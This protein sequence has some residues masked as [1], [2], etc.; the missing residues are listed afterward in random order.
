MKQLRPFIVVEKSVRLVTR[1]VTVHA[2]TAEAAI[3]LASRPRVTWDTV[4]EDT[5]EETFMAYDKQND[6]EQATTVNIPHPA[7]ERLPK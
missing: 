1:S 5:R 3:L 2:E 7:E 4:I 6:A